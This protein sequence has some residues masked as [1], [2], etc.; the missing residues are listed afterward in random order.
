[1]TS[2]PFPNSIS[3][4]IALS[5]LDHSTFYFAGFLSSD[6]TSRKKEIEL[7][8]AKN[9][10]TVIMDTPYRLKAIISDIASSRLKNRKFFLACNLNSIHE[11]NFYGTFAEIQKASESLVKPE[12]I[13][14]ISG[15]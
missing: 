2:T 8:A 5:G 1:M 6:H 4:A 15:S 13:L 11:K 3:L 7:I 9:E 10:T 14:V 12:F